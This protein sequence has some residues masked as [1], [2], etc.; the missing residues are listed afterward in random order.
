MVL[1]IKCGLTFIERVTTLHSFN[2]LGHLLSRKKM[3]I[4][5]GVMKLG[6]SFWMAVASK[7][8]GGYGKKGIYTIMIWKLW[9][10]S[11]VC[12]SVIAGKL[13]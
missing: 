10:K 13:K 9:V 3:Y 7:S 11:V 4:S 5:T 6:L 1:I 2:S 12:P 8:S